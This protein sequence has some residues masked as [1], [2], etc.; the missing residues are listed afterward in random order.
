MLAIRAIELCKKYQ[1]YKSSGDVLK[2]VIFLGKRCYHQDF[3]ALKDINME[4]LMGTSLGIVGENGAGKSTLLSIFTGSLNPTC[5]EVVINGRLS[6]ILELGVGFNSEFT[7]RDNIYINCSILGMSKREIDEKFQSIV[8]FSEL[9]TFIEQPIKTYSSGMQVRLAFSVATS[10]DPEILI[11]DEALA[12]GDQHFQ[13]KCV[14]RILRFREEGKTIL[15]CSH[16]MYLIKQ[17]CDRA[18]W[19]KDGQIAALG[20]VNEVVNQYVD[21]ER[22]KDSQHNSVSTSVTKDKDKGE[23]KVGRYTNIINSLDKPIIQEVFLTDGNGNSKEVFKTGD[24]MEVGV[25]S[26]VQPPGESGV[27][28]VVIMR[29]D[30]VECYGV[31]TQVDG[32]EMKE[33]ESGCYYVKLKYPSLALLS[34]KYYLNIYLLD[35]TGVHVYD[36]VKTL[37]FQVRHDSIELGMVFLDHQWLI[38]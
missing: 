38:D 4:V 2:E 3:W 11:V 9:G 1:L 16:S 17:I 8:D 27:V 6:A 14:D 22:A 13:K 29:N 21:Y 36:T 7:G 12:V 32:V 31:S 26:H 28:G 30:N 25:Y 37:S 20:D 34:G 23:F 15:F 35:K 33:I 18:M 24:T 19:L 5:G 10:I